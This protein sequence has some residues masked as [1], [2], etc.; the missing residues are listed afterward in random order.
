[1]RWSKLRIDCKDESTVM[2][3]RIQNG[4]VEH[5]TVDSSVEFG[6][7]AEV[8]WERLTS[9]ALRSHVMT[10]SVVATGCLT[11]WELMLRGGPVLNPV[12]CPEMDYYGARNMSKG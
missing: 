7:R 12:Y 11:G 10:R 2:E 9:E 1:M 8:H 4:Q 6:A 3:Y 5:R